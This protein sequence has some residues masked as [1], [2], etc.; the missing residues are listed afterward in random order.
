MAEEEAQGAGQRAQGIPVRD[1]SR[2][3]LCAFLSFSPH[4]GFFP[5]AL[6]LSPCTPLGLDLGDPGR[7]NE[8]I[9]ATQRTSPA[10]LFPIPH[11]PLPP[12]PVGW[13]D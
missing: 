2:R 3:H 11:C 7:I 4:R 12:D 10:P 13:T 1:S 5:S 6:C 9:G 8:E